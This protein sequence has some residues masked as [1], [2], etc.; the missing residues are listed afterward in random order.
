M[1]KLIFSLFLFLNLQL[2]AQNKSPFIE[3]VL[4]GQWWDCGG[5][6]MAIN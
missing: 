3:D 2:F 6:L 5:E 4:S 1:N